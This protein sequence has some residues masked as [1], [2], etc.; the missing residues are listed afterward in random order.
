[1]A[2]SE[3]FFVSFLQITLIRNIFLSNRDIFAYSFLFNVSL[4]TVYVITQSIFKTY[5]V[6]SKLRIKINIKCPRN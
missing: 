4:G 5:F 2:V 3:F 1:M 6:K